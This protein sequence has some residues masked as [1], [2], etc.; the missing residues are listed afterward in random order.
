MYRSASPRPSGFHVGISKP[1]RRTHIDGASRHV[2]PGIPDSLRTGAESDVQGHSRSGPVKPGAPPSSVA[3]MKC[4]FFP[5]NRNR[6]AL[7]S[8]ALE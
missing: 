6:H 7:A 3:A 2:E 1:Q 8:Y 5:L 4:R